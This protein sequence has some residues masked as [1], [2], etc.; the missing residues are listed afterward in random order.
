MAYSLATAATA[1][2]TVKSTILRAIKSGKVSAIRDEHG[3]GGSSPPSC[4]G[5]T[6]S[7]LQE[8]ARA[9]VR[10]TLRT[11]PKTPPPWRKRASGPLCA[12]RPM[13][14]L[15]TGLR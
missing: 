12:R 13:A 8:M 11:G 15:S 3:N 1:T 5:F 4:I 6:R 9:M 2:G 7:L 10:A 14:D